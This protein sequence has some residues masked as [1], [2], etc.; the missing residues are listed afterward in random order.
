MISQL[1][2]APSMSLKVMA[3]G[4]AE[5]TIGYCNGFSY[6]TV[7]GQKMTFTVDSPLPA[8]IS[9]GGAQSY[10]RGQM[11]IYLPKGT[12]PEKLGLVAYRTD[13]ANQLYMVASKYLNIRLYDRATTARI[14]SID[15][16][17]FGSYT[18][19]VGA[20]QV[21]R[22]SMQFEGVFVTPNNG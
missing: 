14:L 16:C 6:T 5:K 17:K 19:T 12:T 15:H 4:G 2:T 21:V 8:E 7:N 10:V 11:D 3:D 1:Y 13:D 20:R 9:Q 18:M 22:V